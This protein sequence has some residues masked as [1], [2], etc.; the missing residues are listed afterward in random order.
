M[1]T[2]AVSASV[3]AP[4]CGGHSD[5]LRVW[6][7]A[8][9][10]SLRA[11]KLCVTAPSFSITFIRASSRDGTWQYLVRICCTRSLKRNDSSSFRFT[12]GCKR[13]PPT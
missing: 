11:S 5:G 12:S 10:S 2:A 9:S 7:C 4:S 1:K 6:V 3:P 8:I 13:R